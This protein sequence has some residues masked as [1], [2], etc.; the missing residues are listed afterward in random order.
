MKRWTLF[1]PFIIFVLLGLLL[2]R[3]LYLDPKH[4]PSALIDKPFPDFALPTLKTGE[5]KTQDILQ[6]D[7][8][9][10]VNVWGTWCISC[11]VEHPFLVELAAKGVK[12]IGIN[13][14]D[15]NDAALKWLD[16]LGDP[17]LFSVDDEEGTLSMDLGVTGAPETFIVDQQGVVRHKHQGPITKANWGELKVI[18]DQLG[19]STE[20]AGES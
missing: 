10:L 11:R 12:I 5:T 4:V 1:I 15:D 8:V 2:W 7:Q 6:S 20:S 18:M 16:D 9:K 17:Y 13:Y 3:G 19:S 14:K